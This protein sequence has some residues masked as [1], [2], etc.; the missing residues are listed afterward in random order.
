MGKICKSCGHYYSGEY[1]D[2]CGYGKPA[3]VAESVKK[4]RKAARKKPLRMQ[5][6]EDKKL[7]AKWAK[8]EKQSQ[9]TKRTDPKAKVHFLIVVIIAA[10]VVVV[11]VVTVAVVVAALA[12]VTAVTV[13]G[14]SVAASVGCTFVGTS[15]FSEGG[16]MLL[17][18]G[19]ST[20]IVAPSFFS[21]LSSPLT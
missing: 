3:K 14:S 13:V 15:F 16:A 8:E 5:T 21:P 9:I 19:E 20:G 12:V 2:K 17:S 1:C 10:A 6:E 4:Y 11:T 18:F 7:Y